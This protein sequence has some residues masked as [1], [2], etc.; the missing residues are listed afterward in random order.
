MTE[1]RRQIPD[2]RESGRRMAERRRAGI[3]EVIPERR[4]G[5]RRAD[6]RRTGIDRRDEPEAWAEAQKKKQ[7]D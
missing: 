4:K 5:P 2:R 6:S 7:Q 1:N 3:G